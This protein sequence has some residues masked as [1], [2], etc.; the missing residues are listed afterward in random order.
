MGVGPI[1]QQF[2]SH[3]ISSQDAS[4]LL[5]DSPDRLT[6]KW[7]VVALVACLVVDGYE[8]LSKRFFWGRGTISDEERRKLEYEC[9]KDCYV[10]D[11]EGACEL[12]KE[13]HRCMK[14]EGG[15][16]RKQNEVLDKGRIKDEL[17]SHPWCWEDDMW[18]GGWSW[19]YCDVAKCEGEC[20]SDSDCIYENSMCVEGTCR[21]KPTHLYNPK[22]SMCEKKGC[23]GDNY[24]NVFVK[25]PNRYMWFQRFGHERVTKWGADPVKCAEECAARHWC[26]SF[27]LHRGRG[28]CHL[29]EHGWY[30]KEDVDRVHG[31][32]TW[33]NPDPNEDY[34]AR[35]CSP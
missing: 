13:G 33:F 23:D 8:A 27:N 1:D 17:K 29:A 12:T 26:R 28:D 10:D 5:W 3:G 30:D 4:L 9:R 34:Y 21:C 14:G 22:T 7:A 25:Y 35:Q 18:G 16:C 24:S 20:S 11:Y 15:K 2:L 19:G 32:L 6:M 31:G